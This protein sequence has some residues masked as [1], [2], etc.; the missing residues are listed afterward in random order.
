MN[1]H[2]Y[3]ILCPDGMADFPLRELGGKSPMESADTPN[4]D[5]IASNGVTGL[6][7]TIPDSCLPGSDIGSMSI[8][9]YDPVKYIQEGH[10]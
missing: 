10:R 5:N 4:L 9:G 2:K 3:V 7:K 6:I 8:L 1:N